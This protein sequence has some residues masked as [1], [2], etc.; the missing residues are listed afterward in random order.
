MNKPILRTDTSIGSVQAEEDTTFLINCYVDNEAL[1]TVRDLS[2]SK[3]FVLGST[4]CGKSAL[5]QMIEHHEEKATFLDLDDMAMNYIANSDN[6]MFLKKIGVDLSFFFRYLW[7]HVMCIEL[8]KMAKNFDEHDDR[9]STFFSRL[10]QGNSG[11]QKIFED[12]VGSHKNQ[13]WNTIDRTIIEETEK[14][15]KKVE[16][17]FGGEIHKAKTRAAYA[18]NLGKDKTE[19]FQERAKKFVNSALLSDLARIISAISSELSNQSRKYFLLIDR[20]D[21]HWVDPELKNVLIHSLF[22]A[23]K[24]MRKIRNFKPVI[25]L[26]NDV[27]E[28]MNLE[29]PPSKTQLEKNEDYIVR[30]R[31]SKDQLWQLVD[32][33]IN[34]LFR[35]KYTSENVH[36][37]DVFKKSYSGKESSWNYIFERTLM[38]PRDAIKFVNACFGVATGKTEISKSDFSTAE[39]VY[40]EDRY[41]ALIHE[42]E[43]VF[44]SAEVIL[45]LLKGRPKHFSASELMTSQLTE[46]LFYQVGY[47]EKTQSDPLWVKINS[48]VDGDNGDAHFALGQEVLHRLHLMSAVGIKPD[49][50]TSWQWF[51][52][53][54][55]P[56]SVDAIDLQTKVNV[57]PMLW[58]KLSSA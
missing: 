55:K 2:N 51:H 12:F 19:H 45:S 20:I 10:F 32:T 42:W 47:T 56:I 57:H 28:K 43:K 15:E 46:H 34:Y 39:G 35:W 37:F 9:Q 21:E 8:L 25:A 48:L 23:S 33:R 6:I 54:Q 16:A 18:K 36:F 13:F 41:E 27:Y 44:P 22:E 30:I 3:M 5:L 4:G 50:S 29:H 38:R 14:L 1:A 7:M 53:S 58:R 26:R 40:S 31:W 52:R 11:N 17:E 49:S 24:K